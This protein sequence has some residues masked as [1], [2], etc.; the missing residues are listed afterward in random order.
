MGLVQ[1]GDPIS[2]DPSRH[3]QFGT[4]GLGML[5]AEAVATV[6][7]G[8][9]P[10]SG[11]AQFFICVADQPALDGL[12]NVFA[13]VTDGIRV[14]ERISIAPVDGE[15]RIT[16][17]IEI[18]S[19]TIRDKPPSAPEPFSTESA[20]DLARY[21]VVLET[22]FSQIVIG[23]LPDQA[24]EHV[25]NFLRLASAGIYHGMA[26]H[27][28]AKGFVIQTGFLPSRNEPLRQ[29]QER[30]VRTLQPEFNDIAHDQG[31]VSKA[32]GDD[33]A[34]RPRRSSS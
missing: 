21:R 22:S 32:R 4:G 33:P 9:D 12:Y 31:V 2:T 19:V 28:V 13:R 6:L 18:R 27:R 17:R 5:R 24:P 8:D 23:V 10:D 20:E 25:R 30:Y 11:G 16:E 7:A 26:F 1:G 34:R 14:V 15:G 3:D 29:S